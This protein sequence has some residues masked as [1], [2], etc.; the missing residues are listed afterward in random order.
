MAISILYPRVNQQL[1]GMQVIRLNNSYREFSGIKLELS[2]LGTN[3]WTLLAEHS[4]RPPNSQ[5]FD[6]DTRLF[7]DGYYL[8]KASILLPDLN[9]SQ[10]QVPVTL[11]N[12][13]SGLGPSVEI[14]DVGHFAVIRGISTIGVELSGPD[15]QSLSI[16]IQSGVSTSESQLLAR[17]DAPTLGIN[18]FLF[19]STQYENGIYTLIFK[20]YDGSVGLTTTRLA[21]E[22][23]NLSR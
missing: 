20:L 5:G 12:G 13:L 18:S 15:I 7:P 3:S 23:N 6:W 11:E 1:S 22:I 10:Y 17:L 9:Y 4:S 19:D 2:A 16:F 8:L 14:H 21:L